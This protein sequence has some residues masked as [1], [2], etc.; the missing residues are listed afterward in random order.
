[1]KFFNGIEIEIEIEIEIG[2]GIE[3]ERRKKF[4][5]VVCWFLLWVMM[6][7]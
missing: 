3:I 7:S 1:M 4:R 5:V 2:I 6:I